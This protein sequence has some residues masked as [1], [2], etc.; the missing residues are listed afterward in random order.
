M[1]QETWENLETEGSCQQQEMKGE[2]EGQ[3]E[4]ALVGMLIVVGES[5]ILELPAPPC[6]LLSWVTC[7]PSP[8]MHWS[9]VVSPCP[10][11]IPTPS[12]F[13]VLGRRQDFAVQ[14]RAG[15]VGGIRVDQGQVICQPF[16]LILFLFLTVLLIIFILTT[17]SYSLWLHR[18]PN[19]ESEPQWAGHCTGVIKRQQPGQHVAGGKRWRQ[20]T[21]REREEGGLNYSEMIIIGINSSSL[22]IP[23]VQ[24][25]S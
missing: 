8:V 14:G 4:L 18:S 3:G 5:G 11:I 15:Q 19:Q 6:H 7:E 16:L 1:S 12:C 9:L 24:P 25:L 22:S 21:E 23:T 2:T 20:T 17:I 13:C 10:K